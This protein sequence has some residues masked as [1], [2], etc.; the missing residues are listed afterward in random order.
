MQ[1]CERCKLEG[2]NT[3]VFEHDE[4][5]L[6]DG[7]IF[8]YLCV[9]CKSA[10]SIFVLAHPLSREDINI[11]SRKLHDAFAARTGVLVRRDLIVDTLEG[12]RLLQLAW[13]GVAQTWLGRTKDNA[14]VTRTTEDV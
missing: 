4:T 2:Q 3:L 1:A 12:E 13:C 10:W 9:R 6:V 7:C 11:E 8:T 5:Q 14:D